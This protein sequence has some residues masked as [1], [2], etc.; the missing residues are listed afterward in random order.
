MPPVLFSTPQKGHFPSF[1][2]CE[3]ISQSELNSR[4][5]RDYSRVFSSHGKQSSKAVCLEEPLVAEPGLMPKWSNSKSKR[6]SYVGTA[7][8]PGLFSNSNQPHTCGGLHAKN[9]DMQLCN[10]CQPSSTLRMSS[11]TLKMS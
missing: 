1:S 9:V 8:I 5:L 11:V 4:S 2:S 10:L 6:E 3:Y 7:T